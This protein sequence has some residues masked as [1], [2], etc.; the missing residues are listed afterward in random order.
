MKQYSI[1][2]LSLLIAAC[3][4]TPSSNTTESHEGHHH[5]SMPQSDTT[6]IAP[7][8]K[9]FFKNLSE[10]QEITLPFV[11]EFGV[12]GMEVEPAQGVNANKGHHHLFVDQGAVPANTMVPMGKEGEGYYHFGKGQILDTLSIEKYPML[13]KGSHKLRLQFANGLHMSYGPAMSAE[14]TVNVK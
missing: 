7:N 1:A 8:Q 4:N 5:D 2:V 6:A 11:V 3:S 9:V 10:G 14:V 13:S 12:E